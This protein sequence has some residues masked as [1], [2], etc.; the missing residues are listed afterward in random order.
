MVNIDA[1]GLLADMHADKLPQHGIGLAIYPALIRNSVGFAMREALQSLKRDGSTVAAAAA[2]DQRQGLQ[3]GAG[4]GGGGGL[5]GAVSGV[6]VSRKGEKLI[7]PFAK[8][9]R[10]GICGD[11]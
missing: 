8:G 10:G 4:A 2:H 7:P 1:G 11:K 9:G 6:R 5:R 3:R